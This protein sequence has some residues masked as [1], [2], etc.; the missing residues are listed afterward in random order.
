MG[1]MIPIQSSTRSIEER[2]PIAAHN[3]SGR[4]TRFTVHCTLTDH[5]SYRH[6]RSMHETW[7]IYDLLSRC[8]AVDNTTSKPCA[9][10]VVNWNKLE[11]TC[12]TTSTACILDI[13]RQM[14]QPFK[15]SSSAQNKLPS[16]GLR[17]PRQ[18]EHRHLV[19]QF[20]F[21]PGCQLLLTCHATAGR[22]ATTFF[23]QYSGFYAS[24]ARTTRRRSLYLFCKLYC[25]QYRRRVLYSTC[26]V[27]LA[28]TEVC[29]KKNT[30]WSRR[31]AILVVVM[32]IAQW[33]MS[34]Q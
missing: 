31:A 27:P 23:P 22:F 16:C 4:R 30:L 24:V 9:T 1:W 14:Q 11:I 25:H 3:L 7:L 5:D 32:G 13:H 18:A 15:H 21:G 2:R 19:P 12:I 20:Y 6:T 29:G 28:R 17:E 33:V 34:N 10:A 8:T 26:T